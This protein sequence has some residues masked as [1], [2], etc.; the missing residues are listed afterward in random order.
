LAESAPKEEHVHIIVPRRDI[1]V[2]QLAQKQ[3]AVQRCPIPSRGSQLEE[4]QGKIVGGGIRTKGGTYT[5]FKTIVLRRDIQVLE[6]A[7]KQVTVQSSALLAAES[8]PK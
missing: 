4:G 8:T 6:L 3:V 5:Y 2:L 7:Q 1:Q